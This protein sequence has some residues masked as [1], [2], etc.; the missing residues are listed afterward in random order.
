M[1]LKIFLIHS[2][3]LYPRAMI[4]SYLFLWNYE[5]ATQI[6]YRFIFIFFLAR[7]DVEI[8]FKLFINFYHQFQIG[9]HCDVLTSAIIL[10][11][12][13]MK[14]PE[15][16][17]NLSSGNIW[18][19]QH[20]CITVWQA[21]LCTSWHSRVQFHRLFETLLYHRKHEHFWIVTV[22]SFKTTPVNSLPFILHWL[23]ESASRYSD[24][25]KRLWSYSFLTLSLV[26]NSALELATP[27]TY[28]GIMKWRLL[29]FDLQLPDPNIL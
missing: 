11:V 23:E 13:N 21:L 17:M 29:L 1:V 7:Q 18:I 5:V 20:P 15:Y 3:I 22:N 24:N 16:I 4:E 27:I 19:K 8:N 6:C 2:F 10:I 25:G 12:I 9:I 28:E 14:V 26:T